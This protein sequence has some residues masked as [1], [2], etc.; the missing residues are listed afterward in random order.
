M[1]SYYHRGRPSRANAMT[2]RGGTMGSPQETLQPDPDRRGDEVVRRFNLSV[3][4]LSD[5][6]K[7]TGVGRRAVRR[8]PLTYRQPLA[9]AENDAHRQVD[10]SDALCE[11]TKKR[12]VGSLDE[13]AVY[14]IGSRSG[15]HLAV[16]CFPGQIRRLSEMEH[17]RFKRQSRVAGLCY[18]RFWDEEKPQIHPLTR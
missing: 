18:G 6:Q 1:L 11:K 13:K 3:V 15:F 16:E 9:D 8:V 14:F 17:L 2:R 12:C 10:L 5:C 4:P 7:G